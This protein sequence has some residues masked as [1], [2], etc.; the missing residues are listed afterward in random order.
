M[1][2]RRR[3]VVMNASQID[4]G[5]RQSAYELDP[6]QRRYY[7][8]GGR[9]GKGTE[10]LIS[11]GQAFGDMALLMNY[12]RA[13][14]VRA[15]THVEM[16]VLSR[17]KFQTV[18]AKYPEDRRRVV[19]DMLTSYMQSYEVSKSHCPL[20]ELVRKVYSQSDSKGMRTSWWAFS[21]GTPTLTIRQA[22]ERIYTAINKESNDPT[23]K[24]GVG[25][26]IRDKL[27]ELR[28]R[29]RKKRDQTQPKKSEI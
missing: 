20:L 11:R 8:N 12:Q 21:A 15:V 17:E 16:C 25:A 26:N 27:L 13:A 22:A 18:L 1:A 7:L 3:T 5:N 28:E 4:E 10:I 2:A 9:D 23:L 14:N 19:V 29:R 6:A 24:F